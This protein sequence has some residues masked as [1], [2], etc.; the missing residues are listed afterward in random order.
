M[1]F[2]VTLIYISGQFKDLAEGTAKGELVE[3]HSSIGVLFLLLIV[4]RFYWRQINLNPV[5]SY[6]IASWQKFAAIC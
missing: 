5:T 4:L 6:Q 2:L 3:L 1:I